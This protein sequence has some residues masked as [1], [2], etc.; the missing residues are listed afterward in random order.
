[1]QPLMNIFEKLFSLVLPKDPETLL[2]ENMSEA[3]LAQIDPAHTLD[4]AKYQAL[5]HYKNRICRRAVWEIKYRGNKKIAAQFSKILYEYILEEISD[6]MA[7]S[8][9]QNPLLIPVP[10]SKRALRERGFNQ[11]ELIAKEIK[12][13]DTEKYFEISFTAL[14]KIKETPHQSKLK[15]KSERLKNL[16]GC[17]AAEADSVRGRNIILIDDVITTGATMK[18]VTKT[19]R[20]AGAKNVIGF[21]IAH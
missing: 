16:K 15:N 7:F 1:M 11:C 12:K 19:L 2:I 13:I 21:A 9:F 17:F 14:K 8:D 18:E 5:F 3:E 20:D 10:A 6:A 4:N